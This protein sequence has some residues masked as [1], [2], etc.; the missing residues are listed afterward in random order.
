LVRNR[1]SSLGRGL[2]GVLRK[3]ADARKIR[4]DVK[5]KTTLASEADLY[6]LI[7]AMYQIRW[8][9]KGSRLITPATKALLHYLRTLRNGAAHASLVNKPVASPR[10]TAAVV[11]QIA[12]RLW[13]E[14]SATRARLAPTTI[15]KTW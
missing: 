3:I 11:S 15:Q 5:G 2:E 6:D 4:L 14:V 7:E 8:K 10:E 9:T 1:I 12:N 13:S